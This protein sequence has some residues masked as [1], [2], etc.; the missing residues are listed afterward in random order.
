MVMQ[1]RKMITRTIWSNILCVM[2]LLHIRRNLPRKEKEKTKKR[3]QRPAI[4]ARLAGEEHSISVHGRGI[5]RSVCKADEL[6]SPSPLPGRATRFRQIGIWIGKDLSYR[7]EPLTSSPGN[8]IGGFGSLKTEQLD[9]QI[10]GH[11]LDMWP[12]LDLTPYLF[13][14]AQV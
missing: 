6:Q 12:G 10:C 3:A 14:S 7:T 2:I 4:N 8:V 9:I 11:N 1:F 5:E 13:H